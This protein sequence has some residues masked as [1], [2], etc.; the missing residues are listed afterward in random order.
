M[1]RNKAILLIIVLVIAGIAGYLLFKPSQGGESQKAMDRNPELLEDKEFL[2]T[3][4][5]KHEPGKTLDEIQKK[6][7]ETGFYKN[8]PPEGTQIESWKIVMGVGHVITLKVPP[9]K[10]RDV[11]IAIEKMTWGPFITEFYP[12]YDFVPIYKSHRDTTAKDT[13]NVILE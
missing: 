3:I 8:F 10:L 11:N 9:S 7:Q 1:L 5:L 6:L 2:L 4:I 12:T 13:A